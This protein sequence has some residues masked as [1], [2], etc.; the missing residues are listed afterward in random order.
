MREALH[1]ILFANRFERRLDVLIAAVVAIGTFV[2]YATGSFSADGGVVFLPLDATLVG[3]VAAAGI[4]YRHGSL[5]GAWV[6][7]F[8]AYA[9]FFAE[10]AFLG[11]SSH[12]LA[13]KLA[14]LFDPV[15]IGLSA[16]AAIVFGTAAFAVGYVG[17]RG[18]NWLAKKRAKL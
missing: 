6:T 10:W 18:V 5:L 1:T 4:G 12:T 17:V 11:L 3:A 2:M 16:L 15:S 9:A 13:G 14:F 7:L 8:G